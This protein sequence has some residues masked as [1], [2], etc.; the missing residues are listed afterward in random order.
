MDQNF[1]GET[2]M[3]A[4]ANTLTNIS[5]DLCCWIFQHYT[6]SSKVGRL[7][8]ALLP[9]V[10]SVPARVIDL[11]LGLN[12]HALL[13]SEE[14]SCPDFPLIPREGERGNR[15]RAIQV[16]V[17]QHQALAHRV[18]DLKTRCLT[19][20]V[21]SSQHRAKDGGRCQ[22][23]MKRV[24]SL[25]QRICSALDDD[26]CAIW[27]TSHDESYFPYYGNH[28]PSGKGATNEVHA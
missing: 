15:G 7:A 17:E 8:D 28:L 9:L 14:P 25:V 13:D 24:D 2:Y 1:T 27:F 23:R 20:L 6:L 5:A 4:A 26:W 21:W 11:A 22:R 16:S 18:R 3:V 19:F 12:P 10:Q